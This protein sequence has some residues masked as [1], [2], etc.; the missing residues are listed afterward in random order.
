[1]DYFFLI[2]I[3]LCFPDFQQWICITFTIRTIDPANKLIKKP[4]HIDEYQM[5]ISVWS[6]APVLDSPQLFQMTTLFS[7]GISG[8]F[9][10][11]QWEASGTLIWVPYHHEEG[12]LE[13]VFVLG[14]TSEF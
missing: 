4:S 13:F 2:Y 3:L 8:I 5:V 6:F 12:V 9:P 14:S 1:M 7:A 11:Y 10:H